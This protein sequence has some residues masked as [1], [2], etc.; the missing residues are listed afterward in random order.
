MINIKI[1]R[2]AK[3]G[4]YNGSIEVTADEL[5][6]TYT[7][8]YSFEVLNLVQPLPRE[9]NTQIGVL[10]TSLHH[11]KVLR[12]KKEDLFTE[13]HFKYLKD[14]LKEYRNIGGRGVIATIVHE[15]WNHQSYDSDP[16]MIKWRKTPM[17]PLNLTTL[18][19]ISG[20]NLI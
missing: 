7:F 19:L 8:D 18:T 15:A 9:T 12:H 20:F 14:N 1:P 4:I 16:S 13:K 11:S 6:E 3:P 5:K 2:N 10:A 17:A